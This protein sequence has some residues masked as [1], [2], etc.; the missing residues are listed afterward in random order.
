MKL[1][2]KNN[3]DY[4]GNKLPLTVGKTYDAK[5]VEMFF[6]EVVDDSGQTDIY[7]ECLFFE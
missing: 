3:D 4:Q 5:Y 7:R 1:R 2:C 6:V